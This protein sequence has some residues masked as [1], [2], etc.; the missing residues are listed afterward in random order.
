MFAWPAQNATDRQSWPASLLPKYW[1]TPMRRTFTLAA[2]LALFYMA[3]TQQRASA[4][5]TIID[6]GVSTVACIG[7]RFCS[8]WVH[9]GCSRGCGGIGGGCGSGGCGSGGFGGGCCQGP[10][11]YA[12]PC[13]QAGP[14]YLYWPLAAHF[15]TPPPM[16]Y[17]FG[18][19]MGLQPGVALTMP[20]G[21]GAPC[22]TAATSGYGQGYNAGYGYGYGYGGGPAPG[23]PSYA[24]PANSGYGATPPTP[25]PIAPVGYY[26]QAPSYWYGQ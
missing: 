19:T 16:G 20:G 9:L 8:C 18:T 2:G 1:M 26:F 11:C 22:N 21:Y 5:A 13:A 14:W 7:Q 12:G 4:F 24:A 15:Q 25:A 6:K 3:A 10:P 23:Y 17:P